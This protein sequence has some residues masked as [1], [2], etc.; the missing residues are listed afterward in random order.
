[1]YV[2]GNYYRGAYKKPTWGQEKP[3]PVNGP[4]EKGKEW[5]P[6]IGGL[7]GFGSKVYEN[8]G[9]IRPFLAGVAALA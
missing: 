2:A 7:I 5:A 8:W 4:W 3:H 6:T 9:T 1:M